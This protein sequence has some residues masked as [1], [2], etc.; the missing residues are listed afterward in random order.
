[1][2]LALVQSVGRDPT[3][4]ETLSTLVKIRAIG[5]TFSFSNMAGILSGP[6]RLLTLM[7]D[8]S[9]RTSALLKSRSSGGGIRFQI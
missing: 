3:S 2:T 4:R 8:S 5:W 7:M 1:M 6:P 9:S